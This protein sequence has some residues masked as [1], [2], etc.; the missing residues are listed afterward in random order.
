MDIMLIGMLSGDA[1]VAIKGQNSTKWLK[2]QLGAKAIVIVIFY[3]S[4]LRAFRINPM[5]SG[6]GHHIISYLRTST[7]RL[8]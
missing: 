8:C 2:V 3:I 1:N 7:S 4:Y 6:Q 5:K